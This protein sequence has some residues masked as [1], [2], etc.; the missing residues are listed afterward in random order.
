MDTIC[1]FREDR[2]LEKEGILQA[3][4]FPLSQALC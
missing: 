2:N 3:Q 4:A 1:C